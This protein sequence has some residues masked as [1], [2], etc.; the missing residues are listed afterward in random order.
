MKKL[1]RRLVALCGSLALATIATG[2]I[3]SHDRNFP[4]ATHYR[5]DASQGKFIAHAFSG[6][7]LWFKGH[8]HLV[9]A[10]EF[11][12]EAQI[13]PDTITPASLQLT[14]NA[15]SMGETSSVFTEQQKQ[16]I[17]KELREIVLE[18]AKYPEIVFRSTEVTG[19][20]L[21]NNQYDVKIGGELTLHGITRHIVIPAQ[22]TLTGDDLKARGEFSI[23]RSDYK[24]KATS[25]VH[26]LVRVRD[27]I[28]FTFDIMGHRI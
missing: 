7:P 20:S 6:G 2:V 17:N 21:G 15:A 10:S 4:A 1:R 18:P 25:A 26:G 3:H 24:V 8:D 28:K 16:I 19:K 11:S 13:T 9:A 22:V 5:L 27:R 12:G 14:V 23:D